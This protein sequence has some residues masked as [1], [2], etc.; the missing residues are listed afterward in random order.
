[1]I[2]HETWVEFLDQVT[3]LR[4]WQIHYRHTLSPMA[5]REME[6]QAIKVDNTIRRLAGTIAAE[7]S[8][9]AALVAAEGGVA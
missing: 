7:T 5:R 1:M 9:A 8:P 6:S 3:L 4:E 2:P